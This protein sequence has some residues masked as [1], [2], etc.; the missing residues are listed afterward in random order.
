MMENIDL[1]SVERKAYM[2]YHQDGLWDIFLGMVLL[3]W[4]VSMGSAV[5]ALEGVWIIV[6]FPLFLGAKRWVTF[7]RL[8][9]AQFPRVRKAITSMIV[10]FIITFM[11]GAL[12]ILLLVSGGAS[13]LGEWLR[14]YVKIVFGTIVAGVLCVLA[15]IHLINRL[16]FYAVLVLL[17]FAGAHWYEFHLKYSFL[18]VGGVITLLGLVMLIQFLRN[19]PRASEELRHKDLKSSEPA[20]DSG[21]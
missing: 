13:G 19:Y 16:Y 11:L 15:A 21:A 20:G 2:S 6:L 18:A 12:I 10:L 9:Y 1:K 17:A 7:P 5:S 3:S 14:N 8:G 4:G